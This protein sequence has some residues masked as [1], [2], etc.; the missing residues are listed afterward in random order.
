GEGTLDLAPHPADGDPEDTLAALDEVDDLVG[1]R[2]LVH[3]GTVAHQGDLG[4]VVH[5]PLVQVVDG[6]ADLLQR[7]PGVEQSLDHLEHEDVAGA[8]EALRPGAAGVADTRLD[9]AGAGPVVELAVGDTGGP[10]GCRPAVPGLGVEVRQR[11]AEQHALCPLWDSARRA[12]GCVAAA[13]VHSR[14]FTPRTRSVLRP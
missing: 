1:A 4:E 2:A 5:A 8:A 12:G 14:S 10:A 3:A 7:D 13:H 11:V 9:E 6:G